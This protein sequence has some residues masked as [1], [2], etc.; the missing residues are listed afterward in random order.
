MCYS[1]GM[2]ETA[3]D[4]RLIKISEEI[5]KGET[6]GATK[7]SMEVVSEDEGVTSIEEIVR[8]EASF[9]EGITTRKST[10]SIDV[11]TSKK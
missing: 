1:Q 6:S 8:Q 9:S 4:Q 7:D 11:M 3:A 2:R 5:R 10:Y